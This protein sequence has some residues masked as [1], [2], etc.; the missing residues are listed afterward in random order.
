LLDPLQVLPFFGERLQSIILLEGF[1][2][3]FAP[4]ILA[5]V[6]MMNWEECLFEI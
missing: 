5:M 1:E 3:L 2:W 4:L 6:V